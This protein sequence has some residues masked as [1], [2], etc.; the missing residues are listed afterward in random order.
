MV[1]LT[2]L[3]LKDLITDSR[4]SA[5]RMYISYIGINWYFSA[6]YK[7]RKAETC[8]LNIDLVDKQ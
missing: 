8:Y 5:F 1:V 3:L 4:L 2:G 7:T 6:D